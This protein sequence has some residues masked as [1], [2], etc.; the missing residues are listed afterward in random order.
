MYNL[1]DHGGRNEL[2]EGELVPMSPAN[3]EHGR[4]TYRV[5]FLIG[6]YVYREKLGDMYA[7]ETG[8]ILQR[9]PDTVRAPD[10]AFMAHE[11]LHA[12]EKQTS[13]FGEI[14]PDLVVEVVSPHDTASEIQM[15]VKDYLEAGVQLIWVVDPQTEM[16][17]EYKPSGRMQLLNLQDELNGGGVLPGF[18]LSVAH[19]FQD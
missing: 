13:G 14:I 11:R 8:F 5:G 16:V 6:Q 19:I 10:V 18:T 12:I 7:A 17:T 4:I 2:V 1:P 15:K 3:I 9:D